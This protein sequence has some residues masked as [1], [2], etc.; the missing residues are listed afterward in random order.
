MNQGFA[1]MIPVA[2]Y[3]MDLNHTLTFANRVIAGFFGLSP[4]DM[5]EKISIIDY[6]TPADRERAANDIRDVLCGKEGTGQE[7]QLVRKDGSTFPALIYAGKIVDPETGKPLGVRGIIIDLTER[8][9]QARDLFESRERLEL[10]LKAGD[11]GIWDVDMRTMKVHDICEW[12]YRTLGYQPE[13]LPVITVNT[14]KSLVNPL[15]L[16]RVLYAF[17]RHMSGRDPLFETE[18]RLPCKDGSWKWVA[19]RGKVIERD[20]YKKPVRLTGTINEIT[21]PK[22]P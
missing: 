10:A 6:I 4:E 14:C 8:R 12:A 21:R 11:I 5:K 7:Y 16:P 13:D 17:F 1:D 18:F 9:K 15:D 3:E 20:A 22:N 19:I 2:I